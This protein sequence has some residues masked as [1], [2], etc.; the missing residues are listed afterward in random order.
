[1]TER[2]FHSIGEVLTL[3]T[4]EFPDITISKIRFLESQGLIDPERTS[5]GYRKFFEDDIERLRFILREQRE[6][7]LPLKVIKDRLTDDDGAEPDPTNHPSNH[8]VDREPAWMSDSRVQ[9][10]GGERASHPA[11]A[12]AA[13]GGRATATAAGTAAPKSTARVVVAPLITS[14][15]SDTSMTIEELSEASGLDVDAIRDLERFGLLHGKVVGR[16]S[17]FGADALLVAKL[18]LSFARH[19][20][21]ARHLRMYRTS[22]EKEVS[23]FEQLIVPLTKQRNAAARAQAAALATE[24]DGLGTKMRAVMMRQALR[25]Y[26]ELQ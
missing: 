8:A 9:A 11:A 20:V 24:L 6:N 4:D 10:K 1:M 17:Y 3:L 25:T 12:A 19:G 22:A 16:N 13:K 18:A 26:I 21:E 5:A 14:T 23:L 15:D 7:F 2:D